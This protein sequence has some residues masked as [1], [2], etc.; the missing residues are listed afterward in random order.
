MYS[1]LLSELQSW[2]DGSFECVSVESVFEGN[3]AVIGWTNPRGHR[4]SI[5]KSATQKKHKRATFC[6]TRSF[7]VVVFFYRARVPHLRTFQRKWMKPLNGHHGQKKFFLFTF[8]YT[9]IFRT[10]IYRIENKWSIRNKLNYVLPTSSAYHFIIC[11][12]RW[13]NPVSINGRRLLN[14]NSQPQK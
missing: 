6:G 14:G 10:H 9:H 2:P 1:Q 5:L 4:F 12:R 11:G 7:S 8:V 13:I 3:D